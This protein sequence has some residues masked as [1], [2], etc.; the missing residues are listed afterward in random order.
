L[1][2]LYRVIETDEGE[3]SRRNLIRLLQGEGL[4]KRCTRCSVSTCRGN[5]GWTVQ[6]RILQLLL[7][8]LEEEELDDRDILQKYIIVPV[9]RVDTPVFWAFH[10]SIKLTHEMTGVS[11]RSVV[12]YFSFFS[13]ICSWKIVED[14]D[15]FVVYLFY[16]ILSVL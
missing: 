13:N 5:E 3:E 2:D 15:R 16:C 7:P 6:G 10:A 8:L 11:K 14:A 12:Q 9:Q 4:E 1:D